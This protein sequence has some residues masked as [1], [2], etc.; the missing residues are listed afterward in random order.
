MKSLVCFGQDAY[1]HTKYW[2]TFDPKTLIVGVQ[3][4]GGHDE[5]R[6][7]GMER[8]IGLTTDEEDLERAESHTKVKLEM[9]E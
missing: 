3:Y 4:N 9:F 7:Q 6:L 8:E 2:R 1:E 5:R